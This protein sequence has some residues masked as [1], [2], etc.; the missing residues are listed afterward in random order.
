MNRRDA[1]TRAQ[2]PPAAGRNPLTPVIVG[3]ILVIIVL[4]LLL[5]FTVIIPLTAEKSAMKRSERVDEAIQGAVSQAMDNVNT[6][7]KI[8]LKEPS[9]TMN[10]GIMA[11]EKPFEQK[12]EQEAHN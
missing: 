11:L 10:P 4:A 7:G 5:L 12:E 9:V 3:I 6:T 2:L 8:F 1:I